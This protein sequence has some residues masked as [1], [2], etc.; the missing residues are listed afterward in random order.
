M[1]TIY[2]HEMKE[3]I[4]SLLLWT[5]CVG[6]MGF[7]CILLYGSMQESM[8]GM[9]ENF[10]SMGAFSEAF[11]M[12]RLS[13]ATLVGYYAT[14][15]GTIHALG[16]AM[17]AA[18]LGINLLSKEED[19]HTADFLYTLPL[20]RKKVITAKGAAL[21][22]NVLLFNLLC[23]GIYLAG[24]LLSGESMPRAELLRYHGMSLFMQTEIA[25]LCYAIS[26][27]LKGNR[28]GLGLGIVLFLYAYDLITR[29]I[30]NKKDYS[31]LSPFS[32][33]NA[34]ELLGGDAVPA[35][36]WS[37]GLCV[38]LLCIGLTFA[39]YGKRDL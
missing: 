11:G 5:I 7:S 1:Y 21:L 28:P 13:I 10:A 39:V 22:S 15:I 8:E 12:T 14:E 24:I 36:A 18:I 29:V 30:P 2:K 6:G 26:A 34:A 32:Y 3:T 33:S 25:S 9:A 31:V 17:F 23:F 19:G 16:G 35:P 38:L 4:K 20:P 37:I 27:F